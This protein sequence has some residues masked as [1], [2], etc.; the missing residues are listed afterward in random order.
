MAEKDKELSLGPKGVDLDRLAPEKRQVR[1]GGRLIDVTTIPARVLLDAA[2]FSDEQD[3][4]TNLEKIE[5]SIQI[6]ARIAQ[7]RDAEITAD[8]LL[9]HADLNQ[10]QAFIRYCLE[11][12]TKGRKGE[13]QAANSSA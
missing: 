4:L 7:T 13:P 6:V 2:K 12:I 8:W 9:E 3:S 5:H 11:P 10:L 1:L